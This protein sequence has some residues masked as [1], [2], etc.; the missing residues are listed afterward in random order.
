MMLLAE[1]PWWAVYQQPEAPVEEV[2]QV[3]EEHP[4]EDQMAV[5]AEAV[6]VGYQAESLVAE[7]STQ[8]VEERPLEVPMAL[9]A[10]VAAVADMLSVMAGH[11]HH[12]HQ[13]R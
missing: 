5:T 10:V 4:W 8:A 3:M 7:V 2:L 13:P 11:H 6:A 12:Q 9:I 1:Y